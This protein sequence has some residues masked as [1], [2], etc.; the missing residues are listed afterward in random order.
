MHV[1]RGNQPHEW[2]SYRDVPCA[3]CDGTGA[4]SEARAEEMLAAAAR[5]KDRIARGMKLGEEAR[6]LG[7]TAAALSALEQGTSLETIKK[8]AAAIVTK[9]ADAIAGPTEGKTLK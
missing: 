2:L 8:Q 5:R 7:I 6:R 4:I 9:M 3:E 1:N